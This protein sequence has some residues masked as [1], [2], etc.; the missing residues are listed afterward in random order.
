MNTKASKKE[1][2]SSKA[3][4]SGKNAVTSGQTPKL[5]NLTYLYRNE[6]P[7]AVWNIGGVF[8]WEKLCHAL[9]GVAQLT[10]SPQVPRLPEFSGCP[11]CIWGLEAYR[12]D[13]LMAPGK[14]K[15]TIEKFAK[16]RSGV[17]LYF[18]NPYL[19]ESDMQDLMGNHMIQLLTEN[20][21][22]R[23]NGVYVA[24]HLLAKQ[25]KSR[26]PGLRLRLAFNY[27]CQQQERTAAYYN[28]LAVR[29]DRIAI[30][31]RD[32]IKPELMAELKDK[33]KFEITVN[34]LDYSDNE[35]RMRDLELLSSI[36]REP[37]NVY[38][39]SE[40]EKLLKKMGTNKPDVPDGRRCLSLSLVEVK[41]LYDMGFRN[42]RIQAESLSNELTLAHFAVKQ[43]LSSDPG[44]ENKLAVLMTTLLIHREP[45]AAELPTGMSKYI[46]RKFE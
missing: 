20:N 8:R 5:E 3:G 13:P 34:D 6:M 27:H 16:E 44:T 14:I 22:Y 36:R 12:F 43:M 30:D 19:R 4:N 46:I 32:S 2:D 1:Q 42:F 26:Y 41:T 11:P 38:Y 37:L 10:R 23:L 24:S 45:S 9:L 39:L 7:L 31:P 15:D 17:F 35:Y 21:P 25:L 40:R 29:W 28:E 18:D 33:K